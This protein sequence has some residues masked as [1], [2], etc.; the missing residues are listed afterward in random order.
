MMFSAI[1]WQWFWILLGTDCL[2]KRPR[3]PKSVTDGS[4]A[5]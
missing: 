2:L 5:T 3:S 1:I 4:G